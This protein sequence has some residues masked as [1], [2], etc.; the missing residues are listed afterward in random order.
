MPDFNLCIV[1]LKKEI[2]DFF[3]GKIKL[4]FLVCIFCFTIFFKKFKISAIEN[5]SFFI[6]LG[7]TII[8]FINQYIYDSCKNDF[9]KGG[10]AFNLNLKCKPV[11]YLFGK[12]MISLFI[13]STIYFCNF[14]FNRQHY[15]I[16]LFIWIFIFFNFVI[17]NTFLFTML[18]NSDNG[19]LI[20]YS[21][22]CVIPVL[23]F[24]LCFHIK[25]FIL[26]LLFLLLITIS[27]KCFLTKCYYSK[28]FRIEL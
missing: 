23:L 11:E 15:N 7:I 1:S 17:D 14:I 4:L 8:I 3:Y 6:L 10:L 20:V 28:K 26:K 19:N 24:V 21:F 22:S 13:A 9:S 5:N 2:R 18:F 27:V 25:F 16:T 12:K